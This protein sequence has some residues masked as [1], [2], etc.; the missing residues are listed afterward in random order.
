MPATPF[1]T[2]GQQIR[3]ELVVEHPTSVAGIEDSHRAYRPYGANAELFAAREHEVVI[4]GPADCG[5]SRACLE[6]L[7]AAMTKYPGARG[8]IVRKTRKSMTSTAMATFE[9]FVAPE[10]SCKLWNGEEYRYSNGSKIYLFGLDD[11]E[12]LKSFEGDI[13][14]VQ[15]VSELTREDWEILTTRVTGRG[16]TMPYQQVIA[17]LNPREPSFWLYDRERVGSPRFLFAKH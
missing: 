6:K 11:P 1:S 8:A 15:E 10:G 17:D 3:A 4:E 13:A 14:Y 5:K 7:H 16:G 12:R 2:T 9:R